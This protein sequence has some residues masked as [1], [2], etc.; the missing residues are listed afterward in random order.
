MA[1]ITCWGMN[2]LYRTENLICCKPDIL[3]T[4]LSLLSLPTGTERRKF[5][6]DPPEAIKKSS[7][8]QNIYQKQIRGFQQAQRTIITHVEKEGG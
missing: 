7:Q 2:D 3:K 5:C 4:V 1:K 8:N 6:P